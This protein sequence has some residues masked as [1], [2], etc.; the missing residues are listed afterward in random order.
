[1]SY[2]ELVKSN[3]DE[4]DIRS[5]LTG[6][7]QVAVTIMSGHSLLDAVSFAGDFVYDAM[8][9][10]RSQPDFEL[11]GVSFSAF[12]RMCMMDELSKKVL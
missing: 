5:Y 12:M 8:V 1:M 2:S 4:T 10:T 7:K 3:A 9:E 11:R 6:G